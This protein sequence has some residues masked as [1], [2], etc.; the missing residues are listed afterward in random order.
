MS[1]HQAFDIWVLR[2]PGGLPRVM[3]VQATDH[4]LAIE[5]QSGI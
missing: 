5:C 1:R 4:C 3:V 2:V